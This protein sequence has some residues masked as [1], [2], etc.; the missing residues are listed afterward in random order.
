MEAHSLSRRKVRS[1]VMP[2]VTLEARIVH[3]RGA[4]CKHAR[5]E[6]KPFIVLMIGFHK[7]A[8]PQH[9]Q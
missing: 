4:N 9:P 8:H 5:A 7:E 6:K 2:V 3:G 1:S